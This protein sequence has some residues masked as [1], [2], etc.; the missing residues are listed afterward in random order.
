MHLTSEMDPDNT[1]VVSYILRTTQLYNLH[2]TIYTVKT[3][4]PSVNPT[5]FL[6]AY[7]TINRNSEPKPFKNCYIYH[8]V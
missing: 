8:T 1:N 2:F 7:L 6:P 4:F 5:G 3:K